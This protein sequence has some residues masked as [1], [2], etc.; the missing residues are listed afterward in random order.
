[1]NENTGVCWACGKTAHVNAFG[2]CEECWTT[3]AHVQNSG[4]LIGNKPHTGKQTRI[5][6][7]CEA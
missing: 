4:S 6:R 7:V 5:R 2:F 3:H 1:M